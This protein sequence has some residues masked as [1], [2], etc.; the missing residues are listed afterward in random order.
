MGDAGSNLLGI[1]LGLYYCLKMPAAYSPAL[2][3]ALII[4][5]VAGEKY[6]FS[7]IIDTNRFLRYID[8]LGRGR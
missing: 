2:V 8:N 3:M 1:S 5:Q 4:M 7:R 6:S